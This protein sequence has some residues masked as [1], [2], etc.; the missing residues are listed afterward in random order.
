[1]HARVE[2]LH[3]RDEEVAFLEVEVIDRVVALAEAVEI[4]EDDDV[5]IMREV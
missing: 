5:G 4:T 2:E 1:M 3:V